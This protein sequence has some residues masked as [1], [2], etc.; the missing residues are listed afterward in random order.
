MIELNPQADALKWLLEMDVVS[1]PNVLNGIILNLYRLSSSIKNIEIVTDMPQRKL[2]VYLELSWWG[3]KFRQRRIKELSENM[4]DDAL[5]RFQKR[6]IFDKTILDRA[7]AIVQG[8]ENEQEN[9]LRTTE[10]RGDDSGE[11]REAA[12]DRGSEEDLHHERVQ[13]GDDGS[14]DAATPSEAGTPS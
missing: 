13:S 4:L 14:G 11:G 9:D 8:R 3:T 10:S 2:L 1:D 5:P 7:L 6:V 12:P